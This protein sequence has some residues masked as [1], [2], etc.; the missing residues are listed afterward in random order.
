MKVNMMTA[1]VMA[2][3]IGQFKI[4]PSSKKD[5]FGI[6]GRKTMANA[7]L[8]KSGG[9]WI[10][11][12]CAEINRVTNTL[13]KDFKGRIIQRVSQKLGKIR[14]KNYMKMRKQ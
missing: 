10:H 4:K 8:C 11:G 7:V 9:N 14:K 6:C 3:K 1:M 5:P 2:S 12:R 13:E